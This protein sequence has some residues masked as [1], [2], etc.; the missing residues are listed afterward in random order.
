MMLVG[1]AR[2]MTSVDRPLRRNSSSTAT[3]SRPPTT[4]F[5]LHQADR[6]VDVVG[7]VVDLRQ[8]QA[9]LS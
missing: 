6:R 8:L 5:A 1:I 3:V 2:A 4:M 9:A 7:L